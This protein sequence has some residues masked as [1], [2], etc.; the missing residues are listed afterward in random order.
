MKRKN[1]LFLLVLA[2]LPLLVYL[3]TLKHELI[4]DSKPVILEN[5]LLDGEFS[6]L[7]PFRSGYWA[8]TSQKMAGYDYYRPLMI[9]SFMM[10]K[11]VWGLNPFR[12]RLVNLII[13]IAG[14][15]IL[16]FFLD[17]QTPD[18]GIA[19]SAV[20]LFA[21]FPLHLDNITW[22]VGRNDL[23]IF[24]FGLLALYCFDLFLARRNIFFALLAVASY[25]LA[26][27]A[28]EAALFFLPVLLL[29]EL[30][31][32][33]RITVPLHAT[34]LAVT[35]LYWWAKSAVIGR[36]N[37]PV[38]FFSPLWE[39]GRVLLG[40][41]GYYFRS[42][43]FPFRYDLFLPANKV[44]TPAYSLAG[45]LL[46]FLLLLLLR[47]GRKRAP[48][49]QAWIWIVPFLAGH[50]L[51][52]FTPIYPFSISTRYLA[53]PA[54]GLAWLLAHLL[55]SMPKHWG[56]FVLLALLLVQAAAIGGNGQKYRS[57]TAFWAS[58][59]KSCPNDSFFLSKYAGQLRE[60]GDFVNS[61]ILLRRALNFPMGNST[62]VAIALQLAD[63]TRGQARYDES[64]EWLEKIKV[65]TLEPLQAQNRLL[66]L[67]RIRLARGEQAEAEA[68]QRT[69]EQAAPALESKTMR[70]ELCLAF[71]NWTQ[72]RE[73]AQAFAF[74]QAGA[75]L[76]RIDKIQSAF[77]SLS[78]KGQARY[79]IER[80]N[81][82]Y[83]W[84]LWSRETA[85]TGYA[86]QLQ[87]ARLAFLA[88]KEKEGKNKSET[89]AREG[90]ND[91]RIL[92]SL[93]NLFFELQRSD[94]ALPFY[95]RSLRIN[96]RQT[97]L[98]ERIKLITGNKFSE[99]FE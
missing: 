27:F 28:K 78:R 84:E 73:T 4:W 80:G 15:F 24:L 36:G 81:F 56:R 50:L 5:S 67:L 37:L 49:L 39:N 31:K 43:L 72:A 42:L 6:W 97:A 96:T 79:F 51:M 69:L 26:L 92:N 95:Q 99:R 46:L 71:A 17:R 38:R 16:Y 11:A 82:A 89:L 64:L 40:V 45:V 68:A 70:L 59:L 35:L 32:R 1:L 14:L 98:I 30:G 41:L 21:L 48:C 75:W 62:A 63:L 87:L 60:N 44:K 65:L 25:L 74:P 83:A 18:D 2:L 58:A 66:Q 3:P 77:Q 33:R 91:F 47:Q 93:G 10:E 90:A 20:L 9:L 85:P 8:S 54:V 29:H 13:F 61:E 76:A 34:F 23:L 86:E 12:L 53:I 57:E 88:G 55:R 19:R 94:E 7:A 52:V 22:V